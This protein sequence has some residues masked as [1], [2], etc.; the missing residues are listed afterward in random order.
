[1][2]LEEQDQCCLTAQTLLRVLSHGGYKHLLGIEGN[3]SIATEMSVWEGVVVSPHEK[4]YTKPEKKDEEGDWE[5]KGIRYS[6]CIVVPPK[7]TRG[8]VAPRKG[9]VPY[10]VTAAA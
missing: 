3:A 2:T 6:L 9:V 1:M 5:K 7:L 10:S 4:A 8:R